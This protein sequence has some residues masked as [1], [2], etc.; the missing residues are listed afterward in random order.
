[1]NLYNYDTGV[2]DT[3]ESLPETSEEWESY[4]PVVRRTEF[5]LRM[6][7]PDTTAK[8]VVLDILVQE[9]NKPIVLK[10]II[11]KYKAVPAS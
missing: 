1:M 6:D 5:W 10:E 4:L 9:N 7:L 2:L 3:R 8:R 11:A